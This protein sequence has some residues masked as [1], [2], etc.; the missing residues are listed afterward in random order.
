MKFISNVFTVVAIVWL[1]F[2]VAKQMEK[3]ALL[4]R[5]KKVLMEDDD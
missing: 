5:L 4:T 2:V 3:G 1:I